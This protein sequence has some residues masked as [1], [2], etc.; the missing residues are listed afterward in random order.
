ML[1]SGSSSRR[2]CATRFDGQDAVVQVEDLAAPADLV[3]DGF[4]HQRLVVGLDDG[5]DRMAVGGRGLDDAQIARAG[6]GEV[7]RSRDGRGAHRQHVDV[8]PP[9]LEHLLVFHAEPL[10]L[11]HD[12]QPEVLERDVALDQ[13]VRADQDV[14]FALGRGGE[15]PPLLPGRAEP[16]EHLDRNRVAGHPFAERVEVLLREDGRR[17]E[18]RHLAA[19]HDGLEG[20]PD[21]DLG[22]AKS[23]VAA[24]EPV[25]RA[26]LLHVVLGVDDRAELVG[27]FGERER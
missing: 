26:G 27:S 15:N 11:V 6:E 20:C 12:H 17:H 3:A 22:L 5:L 9:L 24:D 16:A 14:H 8:R 2:R 7:K 25:H 19:A 10:L 1:R 13:A 18:N 21:G 4:D 23:D